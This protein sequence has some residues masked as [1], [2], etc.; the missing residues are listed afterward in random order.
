[1]QE[2]KQVEIPQLKAAITEV[3]KGGD[4]L[5]FV[6]AFFRCPTEAPHFPREYWEKRICAVAELMSEC[7]AEIKNMPGDLESDIKGEGMFELRIGFVDSSY[8]DDGN[9]STFT[10]KKFETKE[11][12]DKFLKE[13]AGK[14]YIFQ[15]REGEVTKTLDP[16]C[17]QLTEKVT[18]QHDWR[19]LP[20]M[21]LFAEEKFLAEMRNIAQ[22]GG[23]L[24]NLEKQ[25]LH[26]LGWNREKF[27]REWRAVVVDFAKTER[28]P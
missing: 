10:T 25:V 17:L 19:S 12:V 5:D 14:P 8:W 20:S 9:R 18:I 1:M 22:W 21:K 13:H 6:N 2:P 16:D 4:P 27:L 15:G 23:N 7:Q 3:L 28:N 26:C 24:E 11:E